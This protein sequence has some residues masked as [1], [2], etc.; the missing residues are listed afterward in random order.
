MSRYRQVCLHRAKFC[1]LRGEVP[2]ADPVLPIAATERSEVQA[3]MRAVLARCRPQTIS[4]L[5]DAARLRRVRPGENIY[6]QGE[7]VPLTLI[8]EGYGIAR[9]TNADGR[10]LLS[11]VAPSG[12]LFGWS[13]VGEANSSVEIVALTE[14][15]VAQWQGSEIRGL[16]RCDVE[17]GLAA[18]DSM[19]ASLHA[20]MEGIEGFLHQDARRRVLRILARHQRLFFGDPP[21]LTRAHLAGLVGTTQEMTR[22]VLRQLEREGTLAREGR[23]GLRLLRP[24]QLEV[25]AA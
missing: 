19:A 9:R 22:R 21:V 25:Q 17:L 12:T 8:V 5:V 24:D 23:T 7:P 16:I 11:G 10:Q 18:I 2:Y 14:C 13:G 6:R 3:S 15:V 4:A 20:T 1:I